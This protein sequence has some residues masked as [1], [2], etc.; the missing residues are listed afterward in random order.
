LGKRGLE[1]SEELAGAIAFSGEV[2]FRFTEENA[3]KQ[4]I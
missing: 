4:Q 3:S 2:D 1:R